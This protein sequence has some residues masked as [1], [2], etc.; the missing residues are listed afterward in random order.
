MAIEIHSVKQN[1]KGVKSIALDGEKEAGRTYIYF[2][3]NDLHEKPF[4]FIEDVFVEKEYR[5]QGLGSRLVEE[6]IDRAKEEG[7]YKVVLTSRYSKPEVHQLYEKAGFVDH[8]K[9]FRID[10]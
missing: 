5:G 1:L 9:E 3:R 10:L 4:A 2:L 7:C 8:G 6:A